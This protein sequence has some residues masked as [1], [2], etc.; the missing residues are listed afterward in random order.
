MI[1]GIRHFPTQN[2][3]QS[4]M[5]DGHQDGVLGWEPVAHAYNT[6]D[7]GGRDQ[8]DRNSKPAQANSLRDPILK[9]PITIKKRA[10]GLAKGVGPEFK[11]Q[12]HKKKKKMVT[13]LMVI[14]THSSL[15]LRDQKA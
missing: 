2:Y 12:Y 7:S 9:I 14:I 15:A 4:L 10:G 13:W 11:P 6:S 3:R 1:Q 5:E 8:E